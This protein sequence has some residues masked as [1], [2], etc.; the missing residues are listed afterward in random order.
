MRRDHSVQRAILAAVAATALLILF[1]QT[2][3]LFV[4]PTELD[5]ACLGSSYLEMQKC[6]RD[7]RTMNAP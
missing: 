1:A 5:R 2:L 4:Q 7:F 3:R 6:V